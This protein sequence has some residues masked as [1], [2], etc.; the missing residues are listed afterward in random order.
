MP[1]LLEAT[2]LA[3]WLRHSTVAYPLLSAAHVM[4]VGCL[5]AMAAL[6]DL[7]LL[8]ALRRLPPPVVVETLAPAAVW[9]FAAAVATGG[10][11]FTV[12]AADY[13]SNPAFRWKLAALALALSN[14]AMAHVGR[15]WARFRTRGEST[16]R[17]KVHAMA[18]LVVWAGIIVAGRFVGFV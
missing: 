17:L 3:T 2:A 14:V 5:F 13:L 15:A 10:L 11:L 6:M 18:S 9:A 1:E 4:A 12:A 16:A 7:R 8:G